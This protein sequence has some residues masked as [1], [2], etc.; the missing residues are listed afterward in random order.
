MKR[1]IHLTI[2]CFLASLLLGF[3]STSA[4]S[5][6]AEDAYQKAKDCYQDVKTDIHKIN[7]PKKW[8]A[9]ISQFKEIAEKYP[10]SGKADSALY[11]AARLCRELYERTRNI[12]EIDEAIHLYNQI[13]RDYPESRLADDALFQ[14][15]SLRHDPLKD[16]ERARRAYKT[17][18]ERYPKGDMAPQAKT[19]L[20]SLGSA[21]TIAEADLKEGAEK[22]ET[23]RKELKKEDKEESRGPFKI[24]RLISYDI[25][26][27]N[28]QTVVT[29]TLDGST[30]FTRKF[31]DYG[32]RTGS[33]PQ[34]M[35]FFPRTKAGGGIAK[36]KNVAS[37]HLESI[38]IKEGLFSGELKIRFVLTKN[39]TYKIIQK[40]GKT[41]IY[42]YAEGRAPEPVN[43]DYEEP[44]TDKKKVKEPKSQDEPQRKL[45]IVIDPGHGG[46]D[47]GAIGPHGV[48][49]KNVTLAISKKLAAVLEKK[50]GA[51][52]FLTR[53]SDKDLS[54]ERRN[55]FANSKK[56]DIFISIHTNAVMDRKISGI[57]TYYLNNAT[58]E[59]ATRLAARENKSASKSQNEVD[60]ILLTLFQNYNTEESRLLAE[61]VHRSV[62]ADVKR[63]YPKAGNRGVRS[64]LF[65]LLVGTKCPGILFE[66]S[67]IS[68]PEEEK[69]LISY[70]FQI[71]LANSIAEGVKRYV[72]NHKELASNLQL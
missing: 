54:L 58:D 7:E 2:L 22:P 53:T 47:R 6:E 16:D 8:H 52:V 26:V 68:N 44:L 13:V 59:A 57:E 30:P 9:C 49:E 1:V 39:T 56:A 40:N 36:E 29:L 69:R 62:T 72:E 43:A 46:K 19:A 27:K 23:A 37:A 50:L 14:I 35:L 28:G 70:A 71:Q 51:R 32:P 3:F 21:G 25:D 33:Q 55:A 38:N 67:Y 12:D 24:T 60:K 61:Q 45:C 41:M 42:F 4:S 48:E 17:L 65:Y 31:V 5:A 64:A 34:L 11:S 63:K 20:A 10:A 66:A 15:G 18:I